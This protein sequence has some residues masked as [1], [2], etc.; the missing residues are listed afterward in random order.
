MMKNEFLK[1]FL[2]GFLSVFT[3][4]PVQTMTVKE[5]NLN[6]YFERAVR[7]LNLSFKKLNNQHERN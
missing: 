6:R 1:H 7:Y 2:V 4:G 5:A 3:F